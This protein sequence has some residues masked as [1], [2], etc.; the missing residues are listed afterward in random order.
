MRDM[1][2]SANL[3]VNKAREA[4]AR[5]LPAH[6]LAPLVE[7]YW[8][9]VRLGLAFHRQLPTI[10]TPSKP[11]GRP[12]SSKP[13]PRLQIRSSSPSSPHSQRLGSYLKFFRPTSN[14]A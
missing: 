13:S 1:L 14:S 12:T 10:E 6:E 11:R 4:G 7:R 8:A 3:A 9:A 2:L 5:A